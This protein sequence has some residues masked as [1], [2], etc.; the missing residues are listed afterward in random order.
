MPRRERISLGEA[1][2]EEAFAR[3]ETIL[4]K[5]R[6]K[7]AR[8]AATLLTFLTFAAG[9]AVFMRGQSEA[10]EAPRGQISAEAKTESAVDVWKRLVSIPNNSNAFNKEQNERLKRERAKFFVYQFASRL[11]GCAELTDED[12]RSAINTLLDSTKEYCAVQG[13]G[14]ACDPVRTS[15]GAALFELLDMFPSK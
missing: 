14:E 3:E 10:G 12:V 1:P 7:G 6:A 5:F 11:R 9:E 2:F 15:G 4:G 13:K 8:R